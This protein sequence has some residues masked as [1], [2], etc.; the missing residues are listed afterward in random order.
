MAR[1]FIDRPVFAWVIAI[2]I[3]LA[4]ALSIWQLPIEQYPK[5]APPTVS[6]SASY[7]GASAETVENSVTQVVEQRL[8]GIDNL[9]YFTSS[10]ADGSMSITLTFEPEADPDIAQVQTQNKVQGAVTQLP[11]EVQAQGVTVTKSN[12]SFLLVVG[13]YSEDGNYTQSDLSDLLV[14]NF[15]DAISRLNGVGNVWVFGD[16]YAMRIWLDPAK[17]YSYNLTPLDVQSAV[18]VQNTDIS[19]GQLGGMPAAPGQQINATIKAQARLETVE[20]FEKIVLRVNTDGSQVRLKDVARLELGSESYNRIARYKR[21][22]AAGMAISLATGAN[23][24]DTAA[25]VRQKVTELSA[26]LPADIKVIYPIDATPFIKLSIESVV[27]TLLEAVVLVFLVMLL[28]LQN[29]RATLIP[30]IAVPVVL[31]GTFAVLLAFGF[32][33]NVLTMFAMVL[34]IGLLVDDAIVVVENVER[35]MSE[36]G[37]PPKEATRKSMDQIT[38]A[39]VGIA[40][41]LSAVFIPMA[42]FG[43]SAGAIYRQFSITIVSA[44]GLSVLVALILSPS[45]CATILKHKTGEKRRAE[46]GFFGWFNRYFN[47][48]RDLY[49][50]SASYMAARAARFLVIYVLLVGGMMAIFSQ[51]PGSF[52]PN[53]DQG[54]MYLMV[55]TPP[56]ATA[57]RTLESVKQVE[58]YFLEHQSESIEHLFTVVGFSFAGSAQNAAFGFVGLKDWK[59]RT[60]EDQSVF[61]ISGAAMG[62][63][64]QIKDAMAFAFFPPPIRELGNAAG[65]ELQLVDRGGLG[66]EALM[67]ARNR[68]LGAAAQNPKLTG[69]RPNGLSDV[70]QYRIDIDSEKASA[71]GLSLNDINRTL[72]IAWGSSYVNDFIDQGR[73]KRVYLQADA[74]HRMMPEDLSKWYV[75]NGN[76]EMIPFNTFSTAEWTYG[77]PK[78][79]RFNGNASVNIQGAPAKGISTGV[80]MQEMQKIVATLP[81]GIGL[82]WSGISYE[83]RAAGAQ[84]PMLYGLSVLIVFLCLAALYESWAVPLAVLLVVPLGIFGAVVAAW[85]HELPND[86]YLQVALLTTV[87]LASKNAILIV[88]FAKHLKEKGHSVVEAVAMAARQRFRPI[89]MTSMAFILGVTPLALAHGA[90]AASQNAIGIAVIGGMIAATFLAIFFVPMFYVAVEKIFHRTSSAEPEPDTQTDTDAKKESKSHD[91]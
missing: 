15:R 80:A 33:I 19:A 34:A 63:L 50:S 14:T 22:P 65:F 26:A 30:T 38:G 86:V 88:E 84:A 29:F 64:S 16:Q 8:T 75:R 7:P 57:E 32:T 60:G 52:L 54:S 68:L 56:G 59:E 67:T 91:Q 35:I 79:E 58:D 49:Q 78:L 4:G 62:A 25:L 31:L 45:L 85:W 81:E 9:R 53:E 46:T 39:L 28:F 40:V 66:H 27:R 21:K 69:V 55:N 76:G 90:G 43:G 11:Q 18:Q 3:M 5:V 12:D 44:M 61:A 1:F 36:E 2:I 24:L 37:L 71:L 70:P 20:D 41:V 83:E 72:Q 74:P 17:L 89:I 87:G 10:S 77:S 47:K 13:V 48:G 73:I 51:L 82:E 6:V 42:F 23:A